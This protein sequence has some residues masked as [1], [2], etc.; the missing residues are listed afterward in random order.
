MS[1]T[2]TNPRSFKRSLTLKLDSEPA[3]LARLMERLNAQSD[4][5]PYSTPH[6]L[7]LHILAAG[8]KVM[9]LQGGQPAKANGKAKR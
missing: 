4:R 8:L 6:A 5:F 1:D 3:R 2:N 9:E 7:G